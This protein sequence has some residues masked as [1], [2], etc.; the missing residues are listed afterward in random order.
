MKTD[1][2]PLSVSIVT[3]FIA[4][5]ADKTHKFNWESVRNQA[6][7]L[8]YCNGLMGTQNHLLEVS[9]SHQGLLKIIL[10]H[11]VTYAIIINIIT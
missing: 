10:L 11:L 4:N 8:K 6:L 3:L 7:P 2:N 1:D 5:S 9:V